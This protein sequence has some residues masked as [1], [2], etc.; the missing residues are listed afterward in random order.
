MS[1]GRIKYLVNT[2]K[3][4]E[5]TQTALRTLCMQYAATI[6]FFGRL[7]YQHEMKEDKFKCYGSVWI[8]ICENETILAWF[9]CENESKQMN[10]NDLEWVQME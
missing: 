2:T 6:I 5:T 8:W 4:M 9:N 7:K 1:N 3:E 10:R